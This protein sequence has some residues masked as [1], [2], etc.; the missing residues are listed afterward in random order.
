MRLGSRG[1]R[2]LHLPLGC[3]SMPW[4]SAGPPRYIHTMIHCNILYSTHTAQHSDKNHHW[5][6]CILSRH[7]GCNWL[8]SSP[9]SHLSSGGCERSRFVFTCA[10]ETWEYRYWSLPPAFSSSG[11]D[12]LAKNLPLDSDF[13][14]IYSH[15]E[16]NAIS[17]IGRDILVVFKIYLV[18]VYS[19]GSCMLV[20]RLGTGVTTRRGWHTRSFACNPGLWRCSGHLAGRIPRILGAAACSAEHPERDTKAWAASQQRYQSAVS[21][22]RYAISFSFCCLAIR[23]WILRIYSRLLSVRIHFFFIC[24][25]LQRKILVATSQ[26]GRQIYS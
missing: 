17:K 15:N 9:P 11:G 14:I 2:V 8:F 20:Q 4:F 6:Q 10:G 1:V 22:A 3:L 18:I 25:P 19:H 21:V 24:F 16:P 5:G 26:I 23:M 12:Q 7:L 13:T